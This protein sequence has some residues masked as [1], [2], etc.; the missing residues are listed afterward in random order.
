MAYAIAKRGQVLL[1][2]RWGAEQ[3]SVKV[4]SCHPGWTGT[5]AVSEAYGDSKKYLEPMRNTWEGAEGMIW[6]CVAPA[7]KLVPGA[8]YLDRLPQVKHIAGCCFSEGSYTKNSKE[9]VDVMM[10]NL[11]DWTNGKR[12]KVGAPEAP[13]SAIGA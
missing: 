12:P 8:F 6:L 1:C 9:E 3:R 5:P 10:R 7:E 11:D 4:V 13:V 2:E